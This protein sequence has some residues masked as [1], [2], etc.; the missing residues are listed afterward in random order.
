MM[1]TCLS[2]SQLFDDSTTRIDVFRIANPTGMEL[3]D[4]YIELIAIDKALLSFLL[5]GRVSLG[6]LW[7]IVGE[8]TIEVQQ[9][10]T[11]RQHQ[12]QCVDGFKGKSHVMVEQLLMEKKKKR[13]QMEVSL[14]SQALGHL[15]QHRMPV[16]CS[17]RPVTQQDVRPPS[18]ISRS[19]V[20]RSPLGC[21]TATQDKCEAWLNRQHCPFL[22]EFTSSMPEP[23]TTHEAKRTSVILNCVGSSL[24]M[25]S[26]WVATGIQEA[27]YDAFHAEHTCQAGLTSHSLTVDGEHQRNI[28]LE[29]LILQAKMRRAQAEIDLYTAAIENAREFDFSA[30]N[31]PSFSGGHIPPPQPDEMCYYEEDRDTVTDDFDDFEFE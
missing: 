6:D 11:F 25:L 29:L 4:A 27:F 5:K 8:R 13:C 14:Y 22:K 24:P 26:T 30:T 19:A 15:Q 12:S 20:A 28:G 1:S 18:T 23:A 7:K 16:H 2:H 9:E 10:T 3:L 21:P 31:K 17:E